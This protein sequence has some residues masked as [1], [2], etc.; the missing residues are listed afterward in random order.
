MVRWWRG[1]GS[2]IADALAW[3][4]PYTLEPDVSISQRELARLRSEIAAR[5]D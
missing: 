5:E 1:A 3:Y 2:L 4:A